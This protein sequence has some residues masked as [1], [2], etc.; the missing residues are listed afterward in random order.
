MS[1]I[2]TTQT[3]AERYWP[4]TN[5]SARLARNILLVVLGTLVLAASAKVKVPFW[6]VPMTLQTGT[7]LLIGLTLGWRLGLATV[8]AYL[9]EGALGLP[10]MTGTPEQGIGLPYMLGPTGGY[11]L[12]F[13]PAVAIAGSAWARRNMLTAALACVLALVPLY[14]LGVGWL[15]QLIGFEK[16][17]AAGLLPFLPGE[18]LKAAMAVAIFAAADRKA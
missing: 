7:V 2:T 5:A 16:A 17:I 11:L 15:T 13:F 4:T 3:M 9:A 14:L 12:G 1:S 10:V 6:P 8:A 18:G